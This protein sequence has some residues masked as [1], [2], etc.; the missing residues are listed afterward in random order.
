MLGMAN[1]GRLKFSINL[2]KVDMLKHDQ[3]MVWIK[4]VVDSTN[5]TIMSSLP[6]NMTSEAIKCVTK[7]WR[8]Y[9]AE[10][11]SILVFLWATSHTRPKAVTTTFLRPLI[12]RKAG[13]RP[14]SLHIR[15]WRFKGPKKRP[16][17]KNLHGF[18][19]G[20]LWIMFHECW[21]LHQVHLYEGGL[22]QILAYHVSGTAFG[23]ESRAV[24]VTY[25]D[26]SWLVWEVSLSPTSYM[27]TL[28]RFFFLNLRSWPMEVGAKHP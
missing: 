20:R 8:D 7:F 1:C 4:L 28:F 25:S 12:G 2:P 27:L 10:T 23:W 16:W 18:L 5:F 13:D 15:R 26:N 11:S 17:R 22:M 24:T 9:W 6:L 14:H 19:R 21:K 3:N